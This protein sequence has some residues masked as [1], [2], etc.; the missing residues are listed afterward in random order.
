M[1]SFRTSALVFAALLISFAAVAADDPCAEFFQFSSSPNTAA[2]GLNNDGNNYA[3]GQSFTLNCGAQLQTTAFF[4]SW[5][6]DSGAVRSLAYGDS[7]HVS[8]LTLD[9]VEL[10]RQGYM[11]DTSLAS[12]LVTFTFTQDG[13]LLPP[14]TYIA[15]CWTAAPA[16]GGLKAYSVDMVPGTRYTTGTP[17]DPASWAAMAGEV[18]HTIVLDSNVT[19]IREDT[20]DSVKAIYR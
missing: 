19:P 6:T 2:F 12:R 9:G 10:A 13:V 16:C 18:V 15:A 7:I 20:W 14:A 5:G 17:G 11:V 4:L 3:H 8:I 1:R